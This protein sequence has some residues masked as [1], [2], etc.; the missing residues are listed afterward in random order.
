MKKWFL[1]ILAA[2]LAFTSC[3]LDDSVYT[4]TNVNNYLTYKDD[5]LK[6]DAG[7]TFTVTHDNTDGKWKTDGN[8]F[9]AIFDVLNINYDI[10]MK[11]YM[12]AIIQAPETMPAMESEDGVHGDPVTIVDC[13]LGGVYLNLIVGFYVKT[14]SD[15]THDMHLYWEDDK[16]TLSLTL[17]HNG[18]GETP[19]EIKESELTYVTRVYCFP[20][21]NLVSSGEQRTIT[22]S[23]DSLVKQSDGTYTSVPFTSS[24]YGGL[25]TF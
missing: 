7:V 12:E 20:I 19:V 18:N 21:Q 3:N 11:S 25:V 13:C 5:V 17:I 22:L 10:A 8:R 24:V 14:G 2:A 15:N 16:R 1:T 9:F 23:V 4:L 6:N